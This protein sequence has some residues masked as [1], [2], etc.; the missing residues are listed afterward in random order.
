MPFVYLLKSLKDNRQYL[1]ST[2]DLEKRL[3]K[4]NRGYVTSTKHRTP[5][6]LKGYQTFETIQEA[7][8]FEKKYKKSHDTL[9]RAI[10]NGEFIILDAGV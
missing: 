5:L 6:I 3:I 1:G 10:K 7:A 8:M 9:N 4:H 2:I